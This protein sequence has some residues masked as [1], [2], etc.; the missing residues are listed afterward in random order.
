MTALVQYRYHVHYPYSKVV[1]NSTLT[2]ED[3]M[4]TLRR[5]NTMTVTDTDNVQVLLYGDM[6]TYIEQHRK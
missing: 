5:W 3:I 6:I 1:F 2:L 4:T